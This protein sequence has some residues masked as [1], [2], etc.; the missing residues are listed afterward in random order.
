MSKKKW[1]NYNEDLIHAVK[2]LS[3]KGYRT[4]EIARRLNVSP[5]TVR[6]IKQYVLR[7]REKE[8][9]TN[10]Q[11]KTKKTK[12]TKRDFLEELLA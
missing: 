8:S 7:K 3:E 6:N 10:P 5:F 2:Y 1:F 11:K 9:G 12:K 4:T